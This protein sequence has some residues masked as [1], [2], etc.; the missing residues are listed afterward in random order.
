[1]FPP[2][3]VCGGPAIFS[4]AKP[5][6]LCSR[7]P[8]LLARS[9]AGDQ[10][11]EE[12]LA[13]SKHLLLLLPHAQP[14]GAVIQQRGQ[15]DNLVRCSLYLVFFIFCLDALEAE[16]MFLRPVPSHTDYLEYLVPM[17]ILSWRN[18]VKRLLLVKVDHKYSSYSPESLHF[19]WHLTIYIR[20]KVKKI[21]YEENC[22]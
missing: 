15:I 17:L 20:Q 19:P 10:T 6:V 21:D 8:G 3:S 2:G 13:L 14:G 22:L 18:A 16:H 1:M 4:V 5:V 7:P 11:Q 12:E 9:C